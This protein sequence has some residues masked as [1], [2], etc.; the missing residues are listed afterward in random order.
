MT[1]TTSCQDKHEYQLIYKNG[2]QLRECQ[3]CGKTQ[4]IHEE[5]RD[6]TQ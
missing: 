3:V 6:Y 4:Y 1:S 5:W 2:M